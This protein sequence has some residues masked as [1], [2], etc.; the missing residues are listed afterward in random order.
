MPKIRQLA[1]ASEEELTSLKRIED[2]VASELPEL[3][4]KNK[5][6]EIL[7]EEGASL[8]NVVSRIAYV[9]KNSDDEKIVHDTGKTL[10]QLHGVM[11]DTEANQA[12]SIQ[13]MIMDKDTQLAGILRPRS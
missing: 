8:R 11:K 10:L 4:P 6:P 5:L 7:E 13:I 2:A 1:P 12:P 3:T 9:N